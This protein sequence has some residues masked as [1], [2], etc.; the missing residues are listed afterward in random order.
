M[1]QTIKLTKFQ[2]DMIVNAMEN[3]KL[4][5]SD[6]RKRLLDIPFTKVKN[7]E[8]QVDLDGMEMILVTQ[9][10]RICSKHLAKRGSKE[11]SYWYRKL[12]DEVEEIRVRYQNNNSPLLMTKKK[13]A[14][15]VTLTA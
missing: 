15:A 4:T 3:F 5:L 6:E 9:S 1:K 13:A 12:A 7:A 14:S 10:L 2:K 8:N 11:L